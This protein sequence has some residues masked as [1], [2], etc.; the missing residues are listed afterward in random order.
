VERIAERLERVRGRIAQACARAGRPAGAVRLIA[1][2]KG[3]P[4]SAVTEAASLGLTEFGENRV[5]EASAKI[6]LVAPRP[7]WHLVGHLQTNKAKRAV[8]LFDVIQSV[9]SVRLAEELARRAGEANRVLECLVEVNTSGDA[10]KFGAAPA[11]AP[12]LLARMAELRTLR[13]GGFMTIGPL[14]GGPAGARVSFRALHALRAEAARA[15]SLAADADLSMGMSD[16]FEIAI[17]EGATMIRV[18]TAL[19]GPR[20]HAAAI[21]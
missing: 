19:F 10:T 1:V 9:D 20:P 14:Q 13:L 7:R 17:E 21:G 3:F 12:A 4:A 18:G 5:Q 6:P 11:D 2:T 16:D 8:E 15:G